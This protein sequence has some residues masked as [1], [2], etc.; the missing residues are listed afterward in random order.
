MEDI[1]DGSTRPSDPKRPL[2]CM[3]EVSKQLVREARAPLPTRPG[4]AKREDD[5]DERR[6]VVNGFLFCEPL[7]GKQGVD[8]TDHR[9][10]V[11]WAHQIQELVN[12]RYPEAERI[13]LVCD[14]WNP[15]TP[16]SLD[17]AFPPAE[18]TRLADKLET[19]YP[20]K[21]GSWLTIAAIELSILSRQCLDRRVPDDATPYA[22]GKARESRRHQASDTVD[23]RF[24]TEDARIKLKRLYP[25]MHE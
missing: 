14:N 2:G 15:H 23:W 19:H 1:R 11:D 5:E 12:G 8:G 9:T 6:G 18:A 10:K 4:Q 21:Q 13:G 17:D 3:D 24:T 16:A 7:T 20:P 25:L 22:E